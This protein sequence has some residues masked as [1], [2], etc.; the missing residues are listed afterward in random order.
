[1]L[2]HAR[3]RAS[4]RWHSRTC[5]AHGD[6]GKQTMRPPPSAAQQVAASERF[7]RRKG[8]PQPP[9]SA[10]IPTRPVSPAAHSRTPVATSGHTAAALAQFAAG[11]S[12]YAVDQ[13]IQSGAVASNAR[14][15][16]YQQRRAT[17][18]T[19]PRL[20]LPGGTQVTAQVTV[21]IPGSVALPGTPG[22]STPGCSPGSAAVPSSMPASALAPPQSPSPGPAAVVAAAAA[23]AAAAMAT[24]GADHCRAAAGSEVPRAPRA[25]SVRRTVHGRPAHRSPAVGHAGVPRHTLPPGANGA[26]AVG[27]SRFTSAPS[28][29]QTGVPPAPDLTI[30][31]AQEAHNQFNAAA[32]A[33]AAAAYGQVA[34]T[35][36][37][38]GRSRG[39][40]RSQKGY[41]A[42]PPIVSEA[43]KPKQSAAEQRRVCE[44]LSKGRC[45][46][47]RYT[48]LMRRLNESA[49]WLSD[50]S[51]LSDDEDMVK[52]A[53]PE[54]AA[55]EGSQQ[56]GAEPLNARCLCLAEMLNESATWIDC[57]ISESEHDEH[58]YQ[59]L[60]QGPPEPE[61]P[62]DWK[63]AAVAR[64]YSY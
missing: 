23:A 45:G 16:A 56:P 55:L 18:P 8:S 7:A 4:D 12:V 36:E 3:A 19:T 31:T 40:R 39:R 60:R 17:A 15:T 32:D 43:A 24:A 41:V 30:M 64:S 50:V 11:V 9:F 20:S 28:P 62:I 26:P 53:P 37:A 21:N 33:R 14:P 38:S 49:S 27:P 47:P 13:A 2:A 54:A 6:L 5:M 57:D 25:S 48:A 52:V 59:N 1:M 44:R 34:V 29:S 63:A 35:R 61:E 42:P 22:C 51:G 10:R 46:D 58:E